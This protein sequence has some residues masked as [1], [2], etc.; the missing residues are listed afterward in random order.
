MR[1]VAHIYE[2]DIPAL[3][4]YHMRAVARICEVDNPAPSQAP[5]HP[6]TQTPNHPIT[7]SYFEILR[8]PK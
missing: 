5:K 1:A 6:I 3:S 4:H 2:V 7:Q 8:N